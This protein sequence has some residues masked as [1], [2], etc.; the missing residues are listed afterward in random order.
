MQRMCSGSRAAFIREL[1]ERWVQAAAGAGGGIQVGGQSESFR[2]RVNGIRFHELEHDE[3][4]CASLGLMR[5]LLLPGFN[6]VIDADHMLLWAWHAEFL[7][8]RETGYLP[9]RE[10]A[11]MRQLLDMCTRCALARPSP[12]TRGRSFEERR[13]LS[14]L[15]E[16]LV[17]VHFQHLGIH[18]HG[19]LAY[20]GFPL[21]EGVTKLAL[22][23]YVDLEG[24]VL[25]AFTVSFGQPRRYKPGG[26]CSNV[27]HLLDL[28]HQQADQ[29][30]KAALDTV[31]AHLRP[32]GQNA[33]P[34]LTLY[35]WRN[36]S[37]HGA[38]ALPTIGG[39]VLTI[40]LLIAVA[41]FRDRYRALRDQIV[42]Q[43]RQQAGG[44]RPDTSR[45][46]WTYYPFVT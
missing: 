27:A 21:L 14:R 6:T 13:E 19:L 5:V 39:T 30:L 43:L 41:Q 9:I 26:R 38:G 36:S 4:Q 24:N 46:P 12:L 20:V 7:L 22:P 29:H 3:L 15:W 32:F 1:C 35:D 10:R 34:L 23:T 25:Q 2:L 44:L 17:D 37:L 42:T 33:E 28:L 16:A 18:A 45:N 31:R 11:D 8:S 40:A